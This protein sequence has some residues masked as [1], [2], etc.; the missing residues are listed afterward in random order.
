MRRTN[1]TVDKKRTK[2]LIVDDHPVVREG[3]TAKLETEA[4]FVVCGEAEDV[5]GA[6]AQIDSLDPDLAII[7]IS[8][9]RGNGIDLIKRIRDRDKDLPILVWSMYAE[10]LYAERALAALDDWIHSSSAV[11]AA[12][13][14]TE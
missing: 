2:I 9:A 8:L 10:S 11:G 14:A 7:D 13:T 1:K 6:L 3:L 12:A 4:N 5:V